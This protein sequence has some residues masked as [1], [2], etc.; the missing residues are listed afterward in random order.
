MKVAFIDT[1]YPL[2]NRNDKLIDSFIHKYPDCEIHAIT[3]NREKLPIT[4]SFYTVHSYEVRSQLGNYV[5][6]LRK[7]FGFY[8][9][10]KT[11]LRKIGPDIIIASHWESLIAGALYK[12]A[13]NKLVYE[14]LDI[15][16]GGKL[17]RLI[18]VMFERLS[19]KKTDMIIHAS[20]F[21]KDLYPQNILYHL[22]Q[23]A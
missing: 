16:T 10:V 7:L 5:D 8:K 2:N 11:E 19:L 20:R 6:K 4:E 13:A 17:I 15:P 12:G 9:Y 23:R 1:S 22:F 3:W 14:N 21:Y 18:L